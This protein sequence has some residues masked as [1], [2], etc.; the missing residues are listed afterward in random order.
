MK[1]RRH[2]T[3]PR[4]DKLAYRSEREALDVARRMAR[5]TNAQGMHFDPLFTYVCRC[6][7]LHITRQ[8]TDRDGK[9]NRPL[10]AVDDLLQAWAME[11]PA[12][13]G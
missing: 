8:A 10:Y 5:N 13:E 6:D 2:S 12:R 9:P 1:R 3:C 4:P 7:K 11:R